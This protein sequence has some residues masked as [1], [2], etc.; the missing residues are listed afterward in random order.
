[1]TVLI[2]GGAYQGK[3]AFAEKEYPALPLVR[4]LHRLVRETLDAGGDPQALLPGLLGK[5]AAGSCPWSRPGS[6][7][8]RRPGGC[9]ARSQSRQTRSIACGLASRSG[10]NNGGFEEW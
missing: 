10:S 9:A 8:G 6:A 2:V 1:M 7:G 5:A 4:G 3:A